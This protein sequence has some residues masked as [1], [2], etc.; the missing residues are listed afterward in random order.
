[1]TKARQHER[2]QAELQKDEEVDRIFN[3]LLGGEVR[4][5]GSLCR[6]GA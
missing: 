5:Q 3:M 2:R 1:M 4:P 6:L